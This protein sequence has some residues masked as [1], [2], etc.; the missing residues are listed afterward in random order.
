MNENENVTTEITVEEPTTEEYGLC[1]ALAW[2]VIALAGYGAYTGVKKLIGLGKRA[3]A[4]E[5]GNRS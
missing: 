5:V 3:K 2:S 1:F 4:K